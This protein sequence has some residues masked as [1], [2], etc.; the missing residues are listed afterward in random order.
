MANLTKRMNAGVGAPGAVRARALAAKA[1]GG[2]RQQAL[3]ARP[4]VLNLPAHAWEAVVFDNKLVTRHGA[5]NQDEFQEGAGYRAGTRRPSLP[6][7]RRAA[8][9]GC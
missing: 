6:G 5:F 7:G 2:H 3:H 8:I 4:I 1:L 9:R